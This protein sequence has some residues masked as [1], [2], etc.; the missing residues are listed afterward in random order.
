M[1][2]DYNDYKA[3]Q[4]RVEGIGYSN[5]GHEVG[6][7]AGGDDDEDEMKMENNYKQYHR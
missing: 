3:L 5:D 1:R 7:D 2:S 4:R 6:D